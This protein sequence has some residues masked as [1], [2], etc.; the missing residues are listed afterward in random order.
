MELGIWKGN[1]R[2]QDMPWLRFWDSATGEMLRSAEER[3]V[4]EFRRAETERRRAEEAESIAEFKGRE[5]V[6][7]CERA[8]TERKCADEA[9]KLRDTERIRVD[10]A[11]K[12]AALLA[13]RLRALGIDPD[14]G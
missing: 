12:R 1:H 2:N 11:A 8:E 5:L 6:E 4:I 13:E 3:E 9:G 14:I 10:M 7:E